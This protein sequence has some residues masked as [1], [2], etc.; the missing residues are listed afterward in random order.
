MLDPARA[1]RLWL[2]VA[3][4]TLWTVRVGCQAE[5]EQPRP[6]LSQLPERHIA[7]QRAT[8]QRSPRVLSGFRRGRL[9]ILAA[10][11]LSQ[12]LPVGALLPEPWPSSS[13]TADDQCHASPP[14]LKVA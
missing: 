8:G 2:A 12:P 3:V 14:L 11:W 4:A 9:V 1:E 5:V 13:E 7:R 6:Q 10:L